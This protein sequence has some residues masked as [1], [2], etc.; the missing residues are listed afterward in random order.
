[1]RRSCE[2]V[3]DTIGISCSQIESRRFLR[4]RGWS[5]SKALKQLLAT[6]EWR[7]QEG[8]D[9]LYETVDVEEY[10]NARNFC[11][12]WCGR[13]DKVGRPIFVYKLAAVTN[14][15]TMQKLNKIPEKRQIE[16]VTAL[17][18]IGERYMFDLCSSL[19]DRS[20]TTPE[21]VGTSITCSTSILDMEGMPFTGFWSLRGLLQK[22]TQISS[23]HHPET[24][25]LLAIVNAPS[26]FS[27]FWSWLKG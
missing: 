17:S 11:P 5:V 15:A 12:K 8:V 6:D 9:Q 23:S 14:P 18:E 1:M 20:V 16:L 3:F 21:Q 24:A 27:A 26:F 19:Q 22:A 4:A 13:R 25:Y 7:R 2:S 10:E